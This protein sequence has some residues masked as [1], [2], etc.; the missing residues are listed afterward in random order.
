MN[1]K[2]SIAQFESLPDCLYKS[3]YI[4]ML[5]FL[6]NLKPAVRFFLTDSVAKNKMI[7]WCNQNKYKAVLH[8]DRIIYISK[9]F[10]L[11]NLVRCI[12]NTSNKHEYILGLLL[13]YPR[14]CCRKISLIG[15]ENIDSFETKMRVLNQ[16]TVF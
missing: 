14:C 7:L 15:E 4:D 16:Y 5:L 2:L 1:G 3:N 9:S 13:G 12:D 8:K 11:S 6:C 10:I